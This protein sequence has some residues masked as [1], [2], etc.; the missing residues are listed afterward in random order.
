MELP[1]RNVEKIR[2][3]RFDQSP[4]FAKRSRF[5]PD[6]ACHPCH[7]LGSGCHPAMIRACARSRVVGQVGSVR[8][9]VQK[10]PTAE[11]SWHAGD[12][13]RHQPLWRGR[14]RHDQGST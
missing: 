6:I 2:I 10:R 8:V 9:D 13:Q 1:V 7:W 4:S 12:V 11:Q 14:A 3:Y 5:G